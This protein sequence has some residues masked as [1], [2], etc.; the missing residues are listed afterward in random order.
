MMNNTIELPSKMINKFRRIAKKETR[1]HP[2][3]YQ[4]NFRWAMMNVHAYLDTVCKHP[5][6][7]S[8]I[9][10]SCELVYHHY[11]TDDN[12]FPV[13]C[14]QFYERLSE[15]LDCT[16]EEAENIIEEAYDKVINN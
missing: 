16:Y 8:N 7:Q 2:E 12:E 11:I 14:Q 4:G 15:V 3:N 5:F 13:I 1:R 9:L 10:E 6:N